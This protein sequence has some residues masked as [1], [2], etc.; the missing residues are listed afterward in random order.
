MNV[1]KPRSVMLRPHSIYAEAQRV[2]LAD[3]PL[4]QRKAAPLELL[5]LR[6]SKV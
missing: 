4:R 2:D 1:H 6:C 5:L 3:A